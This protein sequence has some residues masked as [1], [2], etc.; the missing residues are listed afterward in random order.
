VQAVILQRAPTASKPTAAPVA[1]VARPA[2]AASPSTAAKSAPAAAHASAPGQSSRSATGSLIAAGLAGGLVAAAVMLAVQWATPEEPAG[3]DLQATVD[4][5]STELQSLRGDVAALQETV[6]AQAGAEQPDAA[7]S[8]DLEALREQVAALEANASA[9]PDTSALDSLRGEI[10]ALTAERESLTER[11]DAIEAAMAEPGAEAEVASALAAAGLKAAI[12]RGG[13]FEG[14]LQA[15]AASASDAAVAETLQPFAAEGVPTRDE[16]VQRFPSVARDILAASMGTAASDGV[17]DR[18]MSSALSVVTVRPTGEVQ[19]DYPK[20]IIARM[21]A[22][23]T[24]GDFEAAL[25]EWEKLPDN[26]R[27]V[28]EDYA[29]DIRSRL[30]AD[31]IVTEALSAASSAIGETT[32]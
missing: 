24:E 17:I 21:E 27:S 28:S 18:L 15:Y 23:L 2:P 5:L 13:P 6:T 19:G 3:N 30:E 25:A 26:A 1:S 20:A 22:R 31:R 29:A 10:D 8:A 14:E 11:L 9:E 7:S 16:L 4:N 32:N 12:D